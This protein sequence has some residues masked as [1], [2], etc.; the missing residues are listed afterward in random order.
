MEKEPIRVGK[1]TVS[2]TVTE[3]KDCAQ[4]FLR[5][6]AKGDVESYAASVLK[7]CTVESSK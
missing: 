3:K 5:I 4:S 6:L 2:V 7:D 1:R